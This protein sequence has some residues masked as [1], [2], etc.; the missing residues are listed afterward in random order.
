MAGV[1]RAA[2]AGLFVPVLAALLPLFVYV[3]GPRL[4]LAHAA[5]GFAAAI[6]LLEALLLGYAKVPFACTYVP[7]ENLKALAPIYLIVFLISAFSLAGMEGAALASPAA[8]SK[9]LLF[10]AVGFAAVRLRART[11]PRTSVVDFNE[12]PASIQRL[13]LH[14]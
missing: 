7:N 6:V 12:A 5:L 4:A 1:R 13:G 2:L 10:L 3:L 9:A 11:R 8:A 14:T